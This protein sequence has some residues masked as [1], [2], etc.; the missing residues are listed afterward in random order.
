MIAGEP[1]GDVL[2]GRLMAGIKRATIEPVRFVGIG[3]ERMKSEG[4]ELLFPLSELSVMGI[5][6]I[7]PHLSRLLRRVSQTVAAIRDSQP[8][9]IITVDAPAFC[10]RVLKQLKNSSAVRIH[11]VAPTVWAWRPWRAQKIAS[12]VDHL[13]VLFPF[14]PPYFEAVGL[15]TTFVGHPVLENEVSKVDG[16]KFR[17]NHGIKPN[18]PL[19]CVLP[20]SRRG[21][22]KYLLPSFKK[23]IC[24]LK[25]KFPA[26]QVVVP[27][28]ATLADILR[29]EFL[30]GPVLVTVVEGEEEKFGAM[31]A[32][33]V[34]LAASGTVALE[35]ALFGVPNIVAYRVH[36]L[37]AAI[38]GLLVRVK[39]ANLVN[40]LVDREAVPEFIQANC[41]EDLL[42]DALENLLTKEA[43]M[44]A[45]KKAMREAMALLSPDVRTPSDM[46]AN[47]ILDLVGN[48]NCENLTVR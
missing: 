11:Y 38:V 3:G 39:Y 42:C 2:G 28:I 37:T 31:A 6:E 34:A 13:L 33:D 35:L 24:R 43:V 25:S 29:A 26:L 47:K 32:A 17:Q 36:P 7:I 41:R 40:L 23:T 4:L 5:A 20:G 48:L 21:E 12:L 15:S 9:L 19:L 27:S 16:T 10:F 1:S 45:Q 14:E 18:I 30:H 44:V 8:D 22:I 46:A